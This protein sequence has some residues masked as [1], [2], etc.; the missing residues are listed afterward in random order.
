[1]V[2]QIKKQFRD[3]D[4]DSTLVIAPVGVEGNKTSDVILDR[5]KE[6]VLLNECEDPAVSNR[7]VD[8]ERLTEPA[9]ADQQMRQ[10]A[11]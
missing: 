11:L 4:S 9:P 5:I 6:L 10:N 1:M 8:T 2:I 7:E 3:G